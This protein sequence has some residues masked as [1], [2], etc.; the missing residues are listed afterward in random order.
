[1]ALRLLDT[2][3]A[4]RPRLRL[5]DEQPEPAATAPRLVRLDPVKPPAQ[6]SPYV[7]PAAP[8]SPQNIMD[9]RLTQAKVAP[10]AEQAANDM[11]ASNAQAE[12]EA[13]PELATEF[14]WLD[15]PFKSKNPEV[16]GVMQ[17]M[18]KVWKDEEMP[19]SDKL[20]S[21]RKLKQHSLRLMAGSQ[22]MI[23]AEGAALPTTQEQMFTESSTSGDVLRTVGSAAN[24]AAGMANALARGVAELPIGVNETSRQWLADNEQEIAERSAGFMEEIGNQGGMVAQVAQEV[25][26]QA[27]TTAIRL[28][29][30][31]GTGLIGSGNNIVAATKMGLFAAATTSGSAEDRIKAGVRSATMMSTP[32]LAGKINHRFLAPLADAAMNFTLSNLYG[33]YDWSN[34]VSVIPAL[35]MDIAFAATTKPGQGA[36]DR[37]RIMGVVN[38]ARDAFAKAVG[39]DKAS[40]E[41]EKAA[42]R[43]NVP[44]EFVEKFVAPVKQVEMKTADEKPARVE[45][46]AEVDKKPAPKTEITPPEGYEKPYEG[47]TVKPAAPP[48]LAP[49]AAPEVVNKASVFSEQPVAKEPPVLP[50]G[51]KLGQHASKMADKF[52]KRGESALA[53]RMRENPDNWYEVVGDKAIAEYI[54]GMSDSELRDA[55]TM[56]STDSVG[57]RSVALVAALKVNEDNW[58]KSVKLAEDY[59]KAVD[60]GHDDKAIGI[61][62]QLDNLES[63]IEKVTPVASARASAAG[64]ELRLAKM[65]STPMGEFSRIMSTLNKNDLSLRKLPQEQLKIHL[66]KADDSS[67]RLMELEEQYRNGILDKK[68]GREQV[69]RE[70]TELAKSNNKANRIIKSAFPPSAGD[71][72]TELLQGALLTHISEGRNPLYNIAYASY[73]IPRDALA[74]AGDMLRVSGS[75]LLGKALSKVP[76]ATAQKVGK[77]LTE[78]ERADKAK[79]ARDIL[80]GMSEGWGEAAHTARHG[81]QKGESVRPL[82]ETIHGMRPWIAIKDIATLLTNPSKS[83]L[84]VAKDSKGKERVPISVILGKMVEASPISWIPTTMLRLLPFGDRPVIASAAKGVVRRI[85]ETEFGLKGDAQERFVEMPPPEVKAIAEAEAAARSMQEDNVLAAG[86]NHLMGKAR[87]LEFLGRA[88]KVFGPAAETVARA[89]TSPYMKTLLNAS[90]A[91][92]KVAIPE[93]NFTGAVIGAGKAM[94]IEA[95]TLPAARKQLAE[96]T[97][98]GQTEKAA[99][100]KQKIKELNT[101]RRTAIRQFEA[102]LASYAVAS[103]FQFVGQDLVDNGIITPEDYESQQQWAKDNLGQKPGTLNVSGL[104]RH[105]FGRIRGGDSSPKFRDGDL[106]MGM[107]WTGPI[108]SSWKLRAKMNKIADRSKD[109]K[110]PI[111]KP[112]GLWAEN[113]SESYPAQAISTALDS[114]VAKG[115]N[116]TL[117]AFVSGNW[118]RMLPDVLNTA[119]AALHPRELEQ[120]N[121]YM[122]E[123]IKQRRGVGGGFTYLMDAWRREMAIAAGVVTSREAYDKA[124]PT[125]Y[126]AYTGDPLPNIPEPDLRALSASDPFEFA[127]VQMKP[128]EKFLIELQ[129]KVNA[130]DMPDSVFPTIPTTYT[131]V[132]DR[133]GVRRPIGRDRDTLEKVNKLHGELLTKYIDK[134]K[135]IKSTNQN[136]SLT[137]D[138]L[139]W[140]DSKK[141]FKKEFARELTKRFGQTIVPDEEQQ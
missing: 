25:G 56:T 81:F 51:M 21:L 91:F 3:T 62:K 49:E 111:G 8:V 27:L 133:N 5:L 64:H 107:K 53:Q 41:F 76:G 36:A 12:E 71:I 17:Q 129:D 65:V 92:M 47:L 140:K 97:S 94:V 46:P 60:A 58:K 127:R 75:K 124:L 86:W 73:V 78:A 100:L 117:Q 54:N 85:A 109:K 84:P 83:N 42:Q 63:E 67:K 82:G 24:T 79:K 48:E 13:M 50:Q 90:R 77:Y 20:A 15:N 33:F 40:A 136:R 126:N 6:Q 132:L 37:A 1:M 102:G 98:R 57:G 16:Q 38:K 66:N 45:L 113:V 4:P 28:A 103:G 112:T 9:T 95:K 115:M 72:S 30:M 99:G 74:N 7:T 122:S 32:I 108:G 35:V 141:R 2:E 70:L 135:E 105:Y 106:T 130:A 125:R 89:A 19:Q 139:A 101:E 93:L 116:Q 26:Q 80:P 44:K 138:V 61:R 43:M 69:A 110:A 131:T 96:S 29:A 34:P 118:D 31:N 55:A 22:S 68:L 123:D 14:G 121:K 52:D 134:Y 137:G 39:G 59:Q 119:T 114:T 11:V 18:I 128:N 87:K 23:E 10:Q 120:L 104:M 88:G